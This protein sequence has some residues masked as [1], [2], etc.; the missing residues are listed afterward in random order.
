MVELAALVKVEHAVAYI[1]VIKLGRFEDA[2]PD[3]IL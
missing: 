1:F 3:G 2:F